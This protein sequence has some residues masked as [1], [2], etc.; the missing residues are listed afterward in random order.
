MGRR[1][2]RR[3]PR[4]PGNP[5]GSI[6]R[7]TARSWTGSAWRSRSRDVHI[8]RAHRCAGAASRCPGSHSCSRTRTAS[9]S[10][11]AFTSAAVP[12]IVASRLVPGCA[13][14]TSRRAGP[15]RST[16]RRDYRQSHSEL[17]AKPTSRCTASSI[18]IEAPRLD[19][20]VRA[21]N[22]WPR[23][24]LRSSPANVP[25]IRFGAAPVR[26]A[27]RRSAEPSGDRCSSSVPRLDRSSYTPARDSASSNARRRRLHGRVRAGHGTLAVRSPVV[28]VISAN[29]EVARC[30][31]S[32]AAR[33]RGPAVAL[34]R[35][36]R[37]AVRWH[38]RRVLPRRLWQ[39]RRGRLDAA[40]RDR[41]LASAARRQSRHLRR[42]RRRPRGRRRRARH[43][44]GHLRHHR[45][46]GCG[47]RRS[48]LHTSRPRSTS[49]A[50]AG[51][52]RRPRASRADVVGGSRS[53][54]GGAA[55]VARIGISRRRR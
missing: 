36:D 38:R 32:T 50:L 26:S 47:C 28:V 55:A 18:R 20:V 37:A 8:P 22:S 45:A 19:L 35:V 30:A 49:R 17:Y 33:P 54:R 41:S 44:H 53:R 7:S 40:V 52:A 3:S 1:R 6:R 15:R 11:A 43:Q 9:S 23:C 10:R 16:P 39:G 13:M 29:A 21:H 48:D 14:S 34:R 5:C 42:V 24:C 51:A 12:P 46:D 4:R 31:R 25:S 27:A 2:L